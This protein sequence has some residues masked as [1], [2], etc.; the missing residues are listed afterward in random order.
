MAHVLS[1]PFHGLQTRLDAMASL[2]GLPKFLKQP[3]LLLLSGPKSLLDLETR[4]DLNSDFI[5][6]VPNPLLCHKNLLGDL[7]ENSKGIIYVY[8]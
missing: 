3:R 1:L 2:D 7:H 5:M 4:V 8:V 6:S